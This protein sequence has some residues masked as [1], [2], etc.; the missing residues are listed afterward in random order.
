MRFL[1]CSR[2]EE[3]ALRATRSSWDRASGHFIIQG[4][5][6]R[7]GVTVAW[8][9]AFRMGRSSP[10]TEFLDRFEQVAAIYS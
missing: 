1:L 8:G 5:G 2:V 7:G 6:V 9:G 3:G 4:V 10:I